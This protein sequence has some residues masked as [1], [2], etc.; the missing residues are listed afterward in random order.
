MVKRSAVA[1]CLA[2]SIAGTGAISADAAKPKLDKAEVAWITP[3]IKV[4]VAQNA[5]LQLVSKT[6]AA[7]NAL[8]LNTANNKRL[9]VV[10]GTL[11]SCKKPKDR[12]VAA[13][14][15]PT[16]R[17]RTFGSALNSACIHDE[18]GGNDF[19]KAMIAYTT[20]KATQVGRLLNQGISEFKLAT[21][22]LDKA[23][24][25]ITAAGG[26]KAFTA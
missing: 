12:I 17:M 14:K 11:L 16:A 15:A 26:S 1:V 3:L 18:A 20:V 13:G 7:R 23:Y 2:A 19:A 6:A 21:I 10:V 25:L 5:A 9:A 24:D 4:W 22:Q 8:Y